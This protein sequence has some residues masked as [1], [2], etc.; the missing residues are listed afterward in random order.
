MPD[1]LSLSRAARLVGVSRATLQ[2][3]IRLGELESFDGTV[4]ADDLAQAFPTVSL[5]DN[6]V[7]ERLQSIKDNAYAGR[8]RERILPPAEVLAARLSDLSRQLAGSR[9][10]LN[11][12]Q[13]VVSRLDR[14]LDD[15]LAETKGDAHAGL[16]RLRHWFRHELEREV[17]DIEPVNPILIKDSIL[18]IMA[19]HVEVLPSKHE[20]FVEGTDS[21]LDAALKNGLAMGYGCASGNCGL[22]AARLV[23]GEIRKLR[24]HDYTFTEAERLQGMFLMCSNGPVTDIVIEAHEAGSAREIPL[25]TVAA[26]V[27]RAERLSDNVMLLHLQTPRSNRLRFLAGQSAALDAGEGLRAELPI[28]SC[29]CD[30]RNIEFH[31]RK[32]AS[33]DFS[34][35]VFHRVKPSDVITITG[36]SGDF[37]FNDDSPRPAVF[38]AVENGFAPI[39]SL[40]EH[41]T[42]LESVESLHLY[43]IGRNDGDRYLH[44]LCR[45]WTDA[46]DNFHYTAVNLPGGEDARNAAPEAVQACLRRITDDLP[47]IAECDVYVAAPAALLPAMQTFFAKAGLPAPQY[48]AMPVAG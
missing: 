22:C 43:W 3:K 8:I 25:Q 28:A 35:F 23:S 4:S 5:E 15:L 11:Q 17:L 31:V 9:S 12:Y 44:N 33:N 36:P 41:A 19:A 10:L 42:A 34:A 37:V 18:R 20:F 30:D 6:T 47:G 16:L 29:P 39:K 32:D 48:H 21:I 45:S 24:P 14:T 38:V 2:K 13:G 1:R 26:R 40:V 7:F 27:K 46:L